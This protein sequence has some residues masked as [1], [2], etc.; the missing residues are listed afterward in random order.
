MRS[1]FFASSLLLVVDLNWQHGQQ[2]LH[3]TTNNHRL[4][5]RDIWSCENITTWSFFSWLVLLV[6]DGG[7]SLRIGVIE[8]VENLGKSSKLDNNSINQLSVL[9]LNSHIMS[10]VHFVVLLWTDDWEVSILEI[11]SKSRFVVGKVLFCV[12][13]FN[14]AWISINTLSVV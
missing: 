9:L 6:L 10:A 14:K 5:V 11:L 8:P 13:F 1:Q 3:Q 2:S 4:V 12:C 7:V